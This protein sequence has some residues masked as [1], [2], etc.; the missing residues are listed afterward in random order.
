MASDGQVVLSYHDTLIRQGDL[1]LLQDGKWIND[2]IISFWF[3][4]LENNV[5]ADVSQFLTLV[6]PQVAQFLKSLAMSRASSARDEL[7]SLLESMGISSPLKKLV[8]LP[9]ND[10]KTESL[11]M[12]GTHWSLLAFLPRNES[13]E[14]YDSFSGSV[15]RIHAE[16]VVRGIC[17]ALNYSDD[18]DVDIDLTEMQVTQQQNSYDCGIHLMVNAEGI[19]RQLFRG[20][21]DHIADIASSKA[22]QE[23]RQQLNHLILSLG[24]SSD[25]LKNS[26]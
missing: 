2:N 18:D 19:C 6:S 9:V 22:I 26:S 16:H 23:T 1:D 11:S 25:D 24:Q 12:G 14:H 17:S 7:L 8:L 10:H 21:S 20:V 5:Y 3:E 13:F 15:N 4:Y